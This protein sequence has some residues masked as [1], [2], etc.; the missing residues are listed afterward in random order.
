MLK[1]KKCCW[2]SK[3]RVITGTWPRPLIC[4]VA[5][6]SAKLSHPLLHP[7]YVNKSAH[8]D[9]SGML[10]TSHKWNHPDPWSYCF[11]LVLRQV[12]SEFRCLKQ[13]VTVTTVPISILGACR[14][15]IGIFGF[16]SEFLPF[17]E[18]LLYEHASRL[19]RSPSFHVVIF[20]IY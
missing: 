4:I 18:S 3:L 10:H 1:Q 17:S 12:L 2:V 20:L 13:W 16:F 8:N 19:N 6:L 9:P 15:R 14:H 11:R 5:F 7:D